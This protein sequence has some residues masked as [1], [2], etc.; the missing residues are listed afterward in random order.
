[1]FKKSSCQ[2]SIIVLAQCEKLPCEDM[3][4]CECEHFCDII[5]LT[6][7]PTT[8]QANCVKNRQSIGA[9]L[10]DCTLSF[11]QEYTCHNILNLKFP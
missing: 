1:M 5:S 10:T 9:S 8:G 6:G 4:A 11:F 3:L 2:I 7:V